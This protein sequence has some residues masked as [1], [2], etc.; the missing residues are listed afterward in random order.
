MAMNGALWVSEHSG[1]MTGINSIGTTCATNPWCIKRRENKESVCSKCYA[2]T[3]MKMRK[4][5]RKRLEDNADV[6]EN[7]AKNLIIQ[8]NDKEAFL[9][10]NEVMDNAVKEVDSLSDFL[11]GE[12]INEVK[13]LGGIY[14]IQK[15]NIIKYCEYAKINLV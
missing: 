9:I 14:G 12:I 10:L 6:A 7:N 11:Y 13:K 8:G 4:A 3:Y 15:D 5:L 2:E 1:K